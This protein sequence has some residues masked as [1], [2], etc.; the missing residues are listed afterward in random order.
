MASFV[1]FW[2][3]LAQVDELAPAAPAIDCMAGAGRLHWMRREIDSVA[4]KSEAMAR[5]RP[6]MSSCTQ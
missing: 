2:I 5:R 1:Q 3:L 4:A 6:L